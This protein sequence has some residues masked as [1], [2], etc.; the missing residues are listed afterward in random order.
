[1]CLCV[2]ALAHAVIYAATCA[3]GPA[4]KQSSARTRSQRRFLSAG[5]AATFRVQ[6]DRIGGE[7]TGG[8]G[9]RGV[10]YILRRA[11]GLF[12]KR[13]RNSPPDGCRILSP[14]ANLPVALLAHRKTA[15]AHARAALVPVD[16]FRLSPSTETNKFHSHKNRISS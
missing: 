14:L 3:P 1:M 2:F 11:C 10:N 13:R 5:S 4:L 15:R 7:N 9:A 16:T 8:I 6:R 12:Q